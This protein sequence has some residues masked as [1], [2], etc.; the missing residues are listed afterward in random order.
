V[1]QLSTQ[2]AVKQAN[3]T[4]HT[5]RLQ[6]PTLNGHLGHSDAAAAIMRAM[7]ESVTPLESAGFIADSSPE[8]PAPLTAA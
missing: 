7:I 5:G 1:L 3:V 4:E 6:A 2:I 8:R